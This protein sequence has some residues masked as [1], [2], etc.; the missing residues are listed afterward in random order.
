MR[1][2]HL[3]REAGRPTVM[4]AHHDGDTR[5]LLRLW[6]EAEGYSVVEAADG[7]EAVEPTR[8][9]RPDLILMSERMSKLGGLEAVRRIRQQGKECAFPIVALSSYPTADMHAAAISAGCDSF[10]SQP[11]DFDLLGEIL[12][13]LL[14]GAAGGSRG[15]AEPGIAVSH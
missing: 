5:F 11:V 1:G 7:E 6:L 14:H 3:M 2:E 9:Q 15:V 10:V 12:G 8:G 13:R 4:V